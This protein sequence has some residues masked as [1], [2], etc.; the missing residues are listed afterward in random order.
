MKGYYKKCSKNGS[1]ITATT[2]QDQLFAC[3]GLLIRW[4]VVGDWKQETFYTPNPP[5]EEESLTVNKSHSACS[6][7]SVDGFLK[8]LWEKPC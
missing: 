4:G 8:Y 6:R 7:L 2:E 3:F 5:S 1:I